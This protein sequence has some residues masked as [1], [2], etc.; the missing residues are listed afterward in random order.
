MPFVQIGYRQIRVARVCPA[1]AEKNEQCHERDR[2]GFERAE[3]QQC[4]QSIHF[5]LIAQ[6]VY[7]EF[8]S[9]LRRHVTRR[10]RNE[11]ISDGS[12]RRQLE[13]RIEADRLDR[14]VAPSIRCSSLE[15]CRRGRIWKEYVQASCSHGNRFDNTI[16]RIV[17]RLASPDFP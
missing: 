5:C 10:Y 11:N 14:N 17:D 1:T 4:Y 12:Q 15:P 6:G 13:R 7:L 3:S 2:D 8:E 9:C 16:Q